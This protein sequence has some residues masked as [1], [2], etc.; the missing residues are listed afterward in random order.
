[1]V[2]FDKDVVVNALKK[3]Q[4]GSGEEYL[5]K[6]IQIPF[7]IPQIEKYDV[8]NYFVSEINQLIHDIPKRKFDSTYWNNVYHSGIKHFFNNLRDVTRYINTLR[9]GLNQIKFEVN[10]VD[11]I[12]LTCI[13]VFIPNLY[14]GIRN[15]KDVFR[16][17]QYL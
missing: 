9:F 16:R 8:E 12:A 3:V 4:E 5:E 11:F 7:E 14:E 15:N 10:T 6:M 17:L 13:Q 2:A 1:M